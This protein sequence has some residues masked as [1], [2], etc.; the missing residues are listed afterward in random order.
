MDIWSESL[1]QAWIS[2]PNAWPVFHGIWANFFLSAPAMEYK[3][4]GVT[5]RIAVFNTDGARCGAKCESK[6]A[7]AP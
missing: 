3:I 7:E 2:A 4:G 1:C 6:L 5:D